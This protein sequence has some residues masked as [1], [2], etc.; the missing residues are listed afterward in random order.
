[1][2]IINW[3]RNYLSNRRQKCTI[4]GLTSNHSSIHCGVPQGSILGPLLFLLYVNDVSTNMLHSNILLYANDT[5]MFAKHDDKKTSHLLVSS[6]LEM[7]YKW[8][9]TNQLTI[10][11]IK[12]KFML[13]GTRNMMKQ[14]SKLDISL[15]DKKLQYVKHFNYL[16]I[17]L[18]DTL[19]FELHGAETM[20]L[21]SHKIYLL[22]RIRKYITT[23]QSIAIYK[24]KVLPYFDYSDIFLMNVNQKIMDQLQKLQN[25]ALR[26]RLAGDGKSNVNDVHNTCNINKLLNCLILCI[27]ECM[28]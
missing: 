10:N 1:M 2:D 19:M 4:N 13:F 18:E 27:K 23:G 22:S 3:V 28:L 14:S 17:K 9:Y 25:T 7:L 21:V 5:V 24:S 8:C 26:V 16:G 20:R 12:T 6:H 15:S 11:L